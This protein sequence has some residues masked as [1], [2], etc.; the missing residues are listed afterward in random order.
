MTT[1]T[2]WM[3]GEKINICAS[4]DE[5]CGTEFQVIFVN[6]INVTKLSDTCTVIYGTERGCG[7]HLNNVTLTFK[8]VKSTNSVQATTCNPQIVYKTIGSATTNSN[9]VCGILYEVTNQDRLDYESQITDDAYQVMA[10]ITNSDGQATQSSAIS[11]TTSSIAITPSH[12][13]CIDNICTRVSGAG[14]NTCTIEGST[15]ECLYEPTH[16]LEFKMAFVPVEL[17]DYID[18]YIVDIS[19]TLMTHL[20]IL[21]PPWEYVKTTYNR[22]TNS[23]IMWLYTPNTLGLQEDIISI[24]EWAIAYVSMIVGVLLAILAI[25]L[26]L[27]GLPH[28]ALII[29]AIAAGLIITGY[30][31]YEVK[32]STTKVTEKL[33]NA[34][35]AIQSD[36]NENKGR[37]DIE[38]EWNNSDK[39]KASC[40]SRLESYR[41]I[42]IAKIDGLKNNYLKYADLI[43]NLNTEKESFITQSNT[44]IN[45]FDAQPYSEALCNSYYIN[46]DNLINSS[47]ITITSLIDSYVNPNETYEPTCTGWITKV[48]CETAK[49][50]WY[51][52]KCN[53]EPYCNVPLLNYCLDTPLTIGGLLLGGYVVYKIVSSKK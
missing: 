31:L 3:V 13:E 26:A 40:K 14:T 21:P 53:S 34:N 38:N 43:T 4:I 25:I 27:Y 50:Y 32:T 24:G 37:Q 41:D 39:T 20:P 9:G 6:D 2:N 23:F 18:T 7:L 19:N 1:Y 52:N 49:C 17:V 35:V 42:H 36:N 12:L 44:I 15:T 5:F 48:D 10:C 30:T 33:N 8:L 45:E 29:L 11:E 46:I 28:I 47:N 51:N 16:Y 22:N